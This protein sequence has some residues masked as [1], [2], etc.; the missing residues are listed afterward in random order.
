MEAVESTAASRPR[1][2]SRGSKAA[3]AAAV[4]NAAGASNAAS[5]PVRR[6]NLRLTTLVKGLSGSKMDDDIQSDPALQEALKLSLMENSTRSPLISL[7]V[8]KKKRKRGAQEPE[9]ASLDTSAAGISIAADGLTASSSSVGDTDAVQQ[10]RAGSAS[11]S[12]AASNDNIHACTASGSSSSSSLSNTAIIVP[13]SAEESLRQSRIAIA[14]SAGQTANSPLDG[15]PRSETPSSRNRIGSN[16]AISLLAAAGSSSIDE[17]SP[18]TSESGGKRPR[19]AVTNVRATSSAVHAG[20]PTAAVGSAGA[21]PALSPA[22]VQPQLPT[23]GALGF[24]SPAAVA[25]GRIDS[26]DQTTGM[27][28]IDDQRLAWPSSSSMTATSSAEPNATPAL[29]TRAATLGMQTAL[30]SAI[31]AAGAMHAFATPAPPHVAHASYVPGSS[32]SGA[33][34]PDI[35][36]QQ[37]DD[38]DHIMAAVDGRQCDAKVV[39]NDGGDGQDTGVISSSL[40]SAIQRDAAIASLDSNASGVSFAV[41]DVLS[42]EFDEGTGMAM[43]DDGE[44]LGLLGDADGSGAAS[45][46]E[47]VPATPAASAT[48]APAAFEV[49]SWPLMPGV[50][51]VRPASAAA[52]ASIYDLDGSTASSS[53][54]SPVPSSAT[55]APGSAA[56][57]SSSSSSASLAAAASP[58]ILSQQMP[59]F[60]PFGQ[61]TSIPAADLR[62]TSGAAAVGGAVAVESAAQLVDL[63]SSACAAAA[64]SPDVM[65]Q[66]FP[67]S[68]PVPEPTPVTLLPGGATEGVA[69]AYSSA[70]AGGAAAPMPRMGAFAVSPGIDSA[71]EPDILSQ[72]SIS[73]TPLPLAA[74]SVLPES[75]SPPSIMASANIARPIG[76][77][78]SADCGVSSSPEHKQLLSSRSL[79]VGG[80]VGADVVSSAVPASGA[81]VQAQSFASSSD[82]ASASRRESF[83][84]SALEPDVLSQEIQMGEV[85]GGIDD[86]DDDDLGS[87]DGERS[88]DAGPAPRSSPLLSGM[89]DLDLAGECATSAPSALE[90]HQHQPSTRTSTPLIDDEAAGGGDGAMGSDGFFA[91]VAPAAAAASSVGSPSQI[92]PVSSHSS[93]TITSAVAAAAPSS[94]SSAM[95][96]PEEQSHLQ[97]AANK[98]IAA[99][100]TAPPRPQSVRMFVA[101]HAASNP[102]EDHWF[103]GCTRD[104]APV[105]H[106][107]Q[108]NKHTSAAAAV[109]TIPSSNGPGHEIATLPTSQDLDDQHPAR[110]H[111]A[112]MLDA[113]A[114]G[115]QRGSSSCD[116]AG[117]T[118]PFCMVHTLSL[119]SGDVMDGMTHGSAVAAAAA[120]PVPAASSYSSTAAAAGPGNTS[121]S[122]DDL[123]YLFTVM[124]G[125]GGPRAAEFCAKEIPPRVLSKTRDAKCLA[126]V[127]KG[128]KEAFLEIDE[129]FLKVFS[130]D[131]GRNPLYSRF[132]TCANAVYLRKMPVHRATMGASS[133]AATS[134][135]WMLFSANAGDSRTVLASRWNTESF[136][137]AH[138]HF[139]GDRMHLLDP[140]LHNR[141]ADASG[142]PCTVGGDQNPVAQCLEGH[143]QQVEKVVSKLSQLQ[144]RLQDKDN[145][146]TA[147]TPGAGAGGPARRILQTPDAESALLGSSPSSALR[148]LV[149]D[150]PQQACI[151]GSDG[152]SDAR[153]PVSALLPPIATLAATLASTRDAPIIAAKSTILSAL[154]GEF[155][156]ESVDAVIAAG[157]RAAALRACGELLRHARDIKAAQAPASPAAA[158][159]SNTSV[160]SD[161][162]S[163]RRSSLSSSAWMAIPLSIDHTCANPV[164]AEGVKER[165]NDITAVRMVTGPGPRLKDLKYQLRQQQRAEVT[166]AAH[167]QTLQGTRRAKAMLASAAASGNGDG[168]AAS[169]FPP[170]PALAAN[171]LL[172]HVQ[173]KQW[174]DFSTTRVAGS[175]MVTRALGDLYLKTKEH[176]YPAFRDGCPYITAEPEV[177]WRV[178]QPG[179]EFL[180]LACDGIWD[181]L[182]NSQAV[183]VVAQALADEA[184]GAVIRQ[185]ADG[186]ASVDDAADGASS[187]A[188]P[189]ATGE[190]DAISLVASAFA[191]QSVSEALGSRV[192]PLLASSMPSAPTAAAASSARRDAWYEADSGAAA[193]APFSAHA[194]PRTTYGSVGKTASIAASTA[195]SSSS[196]SFSAGAAVPLHAAP[197]TGLHDIHLGNPA[198]RLLG[199]CLIQAAKK[200][201]DAKINRMR[202]MGHDTSRFKPTTPLDLLKMQTKDASGTIPTIQTRRG[203]HDDMTAIIVLIPSFI[204]EENLK[205]G[206]AYIF[207]DDVHG[208]IEEGAEDGADSD[209]L[210]SNDDELGAGAASRSSSASSASFP[211]TAIIEGVDHHAHP[212]DP[213]QGG[214]YCR[215]NRDSYDVML[216]AFAHGWAQETLQR[217][218]KRRAE[219]NLNLQRG[220]PIAASSRGT[221]NAA[222]SSTGI[223]LGN[224]NGNGGRTSQVPVALGQA[225][226]QAG[227]S[228]QSGPA[229]GQAAAASSTPQA[230]HSGQA[231][232]HHQQ[233]SVGHRPFQLQQGQA[234]P[235]PYTLSGAPGGLLPS[236]ASVGRSISAPSPA[237]SGVTAYGFQSGRIQH[238]HLASSSS[239][240]GQGSS[241]PA[242]QVIR[243]LA[244]SNSLVANAPYP[245]AVPSSSAAAFKPMSTPTSAATA[246]AACAAAQPVTPRLQAA[247]AV[248]A[249][250]CSTTTASVLPSTALDKNQKQITS[251]FSSSG[252]TTP[253]TKSSGAGVAA[254]GIS[255]MSS[256]PGAPIPDLDAMARAARNGATNAAS[257][258]N[259]AAIERLRERSVVLPAAASVAGAQ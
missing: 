150:T 60:T 201:T 247:V 107:A 39:G 124:D 179:D 186:K 172:Q 197:I 252:R 170:T 141:C 213:T 196:S 139:H 212:C 222:V 102:C 159:A 248:V 120:A 122:P 89:P 73:G 198:Q 3:A 188:A 224:D 163:L 208:C 121:G 183:E 168:A 223:D 58:D 6:S 144:R 4:L 62:F 127:V 136:G 20:Q 90:Q 79:V 123:S 10:Q 21:P 28:G 18:L 13:E 185:L 22:G 72:V 219:Q 165:S 53:S 26:V 145:G 36:S 46:S 245:A 41:Q 229:S 101:Q 235:G 48:P 30:P 190:A 35:L 205:E 156:R 257:D 47:A 228:L 234:Q 82:F 88:P 109:P 94:S 194:K 67:E 61:P 106:I 176:T 147:R 98:L 217:N 149:F 115:A 164:E 32:V 233:L 137:D 184:H 63:S 12:S 9:A 143:G 162:M 133:H 169:S 81:P 19:I 203:H 111:D 135:K 232:N 216:Q 130:A 99:L 244:P 27:G 215:F 220:Q 17:S 206:G 71:L 7:T 237:L 112:A 78:D 59:P 204:V 218:R 255:S 157:G 93:S 181:N 5:A 95:V 92:A 256:R 227:R 57:S 37:I 11:S 75:E 238:A 236:L 128:L 249:G 66:Q 50:E 230:V 166:A 242:A 33:A 129:L 117:A 69:A 110:D 140:R 52:I 96:S 86:S 87:S 45:S 119:T 104:Y 189:V 64:T 49:G 259:A 182:S 113:G 44:Q 148:P 199:A 193:A 180:I 155:T 31:A 24:A 240:G 195:L 178:V 105:K 80:R 54:A 83:G 97:T 125:H 154:G 250:S 191:S 38:G 209:A 142:V 171:L 51:A 29:A 70:S 146:H 177:T 14:I 231:V 103:A 132:G 68:P 202:Q 77:N 114:A 173:P 207:E 1:G 16:R 126:D 85:H 187:S 91:P 253:K 254:A 2:R 43:E 226:P 158:A 174:E 100:T 160:L 138:S 116:N 214:P 65:S 74:P 131:V 153:A 151:E 56:S 161:L 258:A 34:A 15:H 118:S 23:G 84:L 210:M 241:A 40:G 8:L 134:F 55:E 225:E 76:R 251:F 200:Q 42:Q 175:L 108:H 152:G 221:L 239:Y 211:S 167:L 243:P 192:P 246:T 25:V